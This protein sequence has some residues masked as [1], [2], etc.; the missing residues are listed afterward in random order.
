MSIRRSHFDDW[1]VDGMIANP[2][3]ADM[4]VQ[5]GFSTQTEYDF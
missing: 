2:H 3:E 1:M 5:K 4:I